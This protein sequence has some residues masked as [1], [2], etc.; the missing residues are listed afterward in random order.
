MQLHKKGEAGSTIA[1]RS[2]VLDRY[3]NYF[4]KLLPLDAQQHQ[5]NAVGILKQK[6]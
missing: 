6:S 5:P 3:K 4:K 2:V 1:L